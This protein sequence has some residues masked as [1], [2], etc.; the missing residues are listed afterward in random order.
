VYFVSLE[1][2]ALPFDYEGEDC[3]CAL[4]D[5]EGEQLDCSSTF[6]EMCTVGPFTL[7]EVSDYSGR[8]Y[9]VDG[10]DN[11]VIIT[12]VGSCTNSSVNSFDGMSVM[13]VYEYD[14][15]GEIDPY[16][17]DFMYEGNEVRMYSEESLID[18]VRLGTSV[19]TSGFS[20]DGLIWVPG[21]I[22]D[23]LISYVEDNEGEGEEEV[24]RKFKFFPRNV[25]TKVSL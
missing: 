5:C 8:Y 21:R 19:Y 11:I 16:I 2:V 14:G 7:Q 4:S 17:C 25:S 24:F 10:S 15:E 23:S 3:T 6:L 9:L 1:S 18:F 22:S 20:S 13:L 12:N